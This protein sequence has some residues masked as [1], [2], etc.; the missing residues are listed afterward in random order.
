[1]KKLIFLS[2]AF[3]V[4]ANSIFAKSFFDERYVEL[5]VEA[6]FG[7]S[8]N[9]FSAT[10]IFKKD[11]VIDLKKIADTIPEKGLDFALY[12]NP[13]VQLNFRFGDVFVGFEDGTDI[14]GKLNISKDLFKFIGYGNEIGETLDISCDAIFDAFA[15]SQFSFG[16]KT[17]K[18]KFRVTP[19]VFIPIASATSGDSKFSYV[20]SEDGTI[21]LNLSSKFDVYTIID[22]SEM[23]KYSSFNYEDYIRYAGVDLG[24]IIGYQVFS[25]LLIYADFRIPIVPGILPMHAS[26]SNEFTMNMKIMNFDNMDEPDSQL[27]QFKY[28]TSSSYKINR[29]LKFMGY[30]DFAPLGNFLDIKAG[31]GLGVRHPF[32]SDSYVYP[33]YYVGFMF[34]LFNV[35]KLGVSSD[36]IDQIFK[37]QLTSVLNLRI[38]E[39]DA[40]ISMQSTSFLKSFSKCGVGA[41]LAFSIG[42]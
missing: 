36:Y 6:P 14:Y 40:G 24:G 25:P 35:L 2:L 37:Q 20:N 29:P 27:M 18:I 1:M 10:D 21:S 11:L 8:N 39:I 41:Y 33:Q 30:M 12:A 7:F 26:M 9:T 38:I 16:L 15:Y 13:N 31:A 22:F 19:G 5:R 42:F 23:E 32:V 4:L 17:G 3:M 34:N 28:D